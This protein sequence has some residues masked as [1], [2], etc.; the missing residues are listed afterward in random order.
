MTIPSTKSISF[1]EKSSENPR[2]NLFDRFWSTKNET[3]TIKSA[4]INWARRVDDPR[5]PLFLPTPSDGRDPDRKKKLIFFST[6]VTVGQQ[7]FKSA[8]TENVGR[9][10]SISDL[11]W[12]VLGY[13]KLELNSDPQH[14]SD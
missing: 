6:C 4:G 13:E 12:I 14:L 7:S 8:S 10:V 1:Q 5:Y 11:Q 3:Q 9:M 2:K